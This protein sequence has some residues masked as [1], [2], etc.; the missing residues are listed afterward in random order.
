MTLQDGFPDDSKTTP[1]P[2]LVFGQVLEELDDLAALKCLLRA[3]WLH[4][5]KRS[6]PRYVTRGEMMADRTMSRA[7]ASTGSRPEDALDEALE[8]LED[9]G[10]LIH[11][12]MRRSNGG[13]DVYMPN[14]RDGR[15]AAEHLKAKG[16]G[17]AASSAARQRQAPAEKPKIFALYEENVGIITPIMAEALKKAEETYS[18]DWIEKAFRVAVASNVRRWSYI[19]AILRTGEKEG[20]DHGE[21]GGRPTKVDAR[22]WIRR[23]GIS[24]PS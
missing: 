4:S 2:N 13:Q 22:E 20:I 17:V 24:R 7:L 15:L 5:Q 19:E 9:L 11:L 21:P 10:L 14:T 16:L 8:N 6:F 3:F 18:A 1:L 23:R 12:R